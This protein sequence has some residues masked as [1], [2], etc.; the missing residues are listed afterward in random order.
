MTA[1]KWKKI[2]A[3]KA[4]DKGLISKI[5]HINKE[6]NKKWEDLNTHLSKYIQITNKNIKRLST[7]LI[8]REM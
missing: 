4:T 2:I 1:L 3:K 5:Y 8:I 6:P 7:L